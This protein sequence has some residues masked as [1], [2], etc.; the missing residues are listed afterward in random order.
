MDAI[1]CQVEGRH[2]GSYVLIYKLFFSDESDFFLG[3]SI[4][5]RCID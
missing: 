4:L 3:L 2:N 5:F 1:I